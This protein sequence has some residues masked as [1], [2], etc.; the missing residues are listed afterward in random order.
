MNNGTERESTYSGRVTC[1]RTNYFLDI[2][3]AVNNRFYLSLTESRR[4]S[5]SGFEQNR[6]FLF[7]EN[8][9]DFREEIVRALDAM[10]N[11]V[12][13]R[14]EIEND[15]T[16]THPRSGKKWDEEEEKKIIKSFKGGKSIED[17]AE[18]VERSS[19]AVLLRLEKL[20]LIESENS[21]KQAG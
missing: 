18:D 19:K 8:V 15:Y 2:R 20:G 1:G 9:E 6:I 13:E 14:G 17:I 7:E 12:E 16:D 11:A 21:D 10:A 3:Q 5:D 4:V